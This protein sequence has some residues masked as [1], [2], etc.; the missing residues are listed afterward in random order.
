MTLHGAGQVITLFGEE[1]AMT[2]YETHLEEVK[3]NYP[4]LDPEAQARLAE[5]KMR[6]AT[7]RPNRGVPQQSKRVRRP[8]FDIGDGDD[9]RP[10]SRS[11]AYRAL[12]ATK[13]EETRAMAATI[14]EEF[15]RDADRRIRITAAEER[16]RK[17]EADARAQAEEDR[18]EAERKRTEDEA[19]RQEEEVRKATEVVST[20]PSNGVPFGLTKLTGV[21]ADP[22][23]RKAIVTALY[24]QFGEGHIHKDDCFALL[25]REFC[26]G[27]AVPGNAIGRVLYGLDNED[28][29]Q[30]LVFRYI[31]G[32]YQLTDAGIALAKE[33]F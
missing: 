21:S 1:Q 17:L 11:R 30:K 20:S 33:E 13:M 23:W 12:L 25:R 31:E 4:D 5:L 28:P 18:K 27:D 29:E 26:W 7:R 22:R 15:Q 6:M 9:G 32:E 14:R 3:R 19:R 16:M 2:I 24:R 10:R 8:R